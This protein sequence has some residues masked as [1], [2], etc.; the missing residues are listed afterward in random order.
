MGSVPNWWGTTAVTEW[1]VQLVKREVRTG[2][3]AF[4]FPRGL[5]TRFQTMHQKEF[6][7]RVHT[8]SKREA[9]TPFI[10]GACRSQ[11]TRRR[12]AFGST[13][14]RYFVSLQLSSPAR[15]ATFSNGP[16]QSGI[17]ARAWA[18]R[19]PLSTFPRWIMIA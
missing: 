12:S 7:A 19:G 5:I 4:R 16:G 9:G 17:W 10:N 13:T 18:G 6:C 1:N 11:E 3:L 8:R 2:K 15:K 14:A